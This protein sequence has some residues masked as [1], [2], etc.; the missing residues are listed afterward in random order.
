M[1][2]FVS[3]FLWLTVGLQQVEVAVEESVSSVEL[4]LDG[5]PVG[6]VTAPD[7]RT[8]VDFG[9]VLQPH[10]L[11]AV[12]RDTNDAELGR[13]RQVVN[14]PRPDAELRLV[15]EGREGGPPERVRVVLQSAQGE[16]PERVT[17]SLDSQPLAQ[18]DGVY[19]LP[20]Y[21]PSKAHVL[22]AEAIFPFGVSARDDLSLGGFHRG[23]VASE[24]TAVAVDVTGHRR[25]QA[26][27][28][29]DL[30]SVDG[31]PATVAGVDRPGARVYLVRDQGAWPSMRQTGV[32]MT[33][34]WP[35]QRR[36]RL[37]SGVDVT[38]DLH[39]FHLVIPNPEERDDLAVF[40]V[41][42]PFL[43]RRFNLPW[44]VSHV[45]DRTAS[46]DGQRL[47]AAVAVAGVRA[48]RES[49]PRVVILV[50]SEAVRDSSRDRPRDVRAYLRS[51]QV[52]LVV[53]TTGDDLPTA[54]GDAEPVASPGQLMDAS[55]DLM[56]SLL[57]Q[58]IV[59]IEGRH[60]PNRVQLDGGGERFRL[61]GAEA[62]TGATSA[63]ATPPL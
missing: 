54:W 57:K 14:L 44:L 43:L 18:V 2:T 8:E 47:A 37:E 31:V 28:F 51:L 35:S 56:K 38:P 6:V 26:E 17:V 5:K 33:R 22:S 30:L 29:G 58:W 12:A 39:R 1:V 50:L 36:I 42:G 62:E 45:F 3:V 40:P 34:R 11:V 16:S 10:E 9:P 4:L 19:L 20:V 23:Q 21:D 27:D 46:A 15:L 55:E 41:G 24:L 13:A 53:W 48:A 32:T 25:P 7:W 59:W 63:V 49:C 61:A 52:P 60:F